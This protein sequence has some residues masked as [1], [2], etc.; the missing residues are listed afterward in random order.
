MLKIADSILCK[1]VFIKGIWTMDS[2][3]IKTFRIILEEADDI[4]Y[5]LKTKS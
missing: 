2:N 3:Y 4:K 5:A 1:L